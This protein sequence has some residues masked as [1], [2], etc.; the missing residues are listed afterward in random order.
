MK[1]IVKDII[2][3]SFNL[4]A[5]KESWVG[6]SKC[7]FFNPF[8]WAAD[9]GWVV[10]AATGVAVATATTGAISTNASLIA[11]EIYDVEFDINSYTAGGLYINIGGGFAI[12]MNIVGNGHYKT[13]ARVPASQN[14]R[15][16]FTGSPAFTGTITGLK[17]CKIV[18]S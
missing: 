5:T 12:N 8:F 10:T 3:D 7:N 4:F 16:Y 13:L 17:V 2:S 14:G 18:I 11:G 6:S 1:N 9:T 15:F